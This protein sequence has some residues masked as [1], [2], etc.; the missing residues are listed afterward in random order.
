MDSGLRQAIR[1]VLA[2]AVT[3]GASHINLDPVAQ[4][5]TRNTAVDGDPCIT[6]K[7]TQT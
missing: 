7:T 2:Q 6:L 1:A 5:F 4:R 3:G